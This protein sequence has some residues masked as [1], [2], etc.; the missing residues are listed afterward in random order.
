VLILDGGVERQLHHG[1]E[2]I[3]VALVTVLLQRLAKFDFGLVGLAFATIV[4]GTW[5]SRALE[6]SY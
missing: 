4:P 1:M 2:G 6:Y 3:E 5:H